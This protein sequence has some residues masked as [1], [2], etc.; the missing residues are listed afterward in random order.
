MLILPLV[1][2]TQVQSIWIVAFIIGLAAA[3]HQGW[4]SNIFT[5]VSDVYPKK[6]IGTMVGLSGFTGAIGGALAASFVGL[7]LEISGSYTLIFIIASAMY[8]LA[9]LILK[10]M[11]P[12]IQQIKL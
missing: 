11:I 1:F 6:A 4:A 7:V 8:L 2:A 10:L 12:Q 9:W 3:A 5:I